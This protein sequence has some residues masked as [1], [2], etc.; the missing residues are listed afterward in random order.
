MKVKVKSIFC[1]LIAMSVCLAGG[2]SFNEPPKPVTS[3]VTATE[4]MSKYPA[5]PVDLD[6]Y[7]TQNMEVYAYIVIPGTDISYPVV[8]SR[9]DDNYYIRRDW[10]GN[11]D[12][13]GS[14]FSQSA[15]NLEFT[16]PVTLLYGHN[17]EK[18][19]MFS[20]LLYF[21]DEQFFNE[22]DTVYIYLPYGILVYRIFSA[23]TFDD[24]HI[25]NSYDFS[26]DSVL[27]D[28]QQLLMNPPV[29]EKNV[30]EGTELGLNSHILILSTC[31]EPRSGCNARYLVNGV[32]IDHV[33]QD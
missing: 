24:R 19:D 3:T 10:K 33:F 9:R 6:E 15:N 8:Q 13:H 29:L 17:T 20:Q 12:T 26:D 21:K 4:P 27:T 31:A 1:L 11:R 2:C 18:G 32:L 22:H 25:L 30:R 28:F 14:V 7:R 5:C 16:N 23:H